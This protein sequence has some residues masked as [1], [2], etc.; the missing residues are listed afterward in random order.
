MKGLRAFVLALVVL[1]IMAGA[2]L[3]QAIENDGGYMMHPYMGW[4]GGVMMI[5]FWAALIFVLFVLARSVNALHQGMR[6]PPRTAIEILKER[7]VR[8]EISKEEFE[9]KRDILLR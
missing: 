1:P 3:G 4:G 2:T 5:L 8:G 6:R 9:E 7:F